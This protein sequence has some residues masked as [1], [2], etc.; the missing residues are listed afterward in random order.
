MQP[1]V[2]IETE[3]RTAETPTLNAIAREA[4]TDNDGS[5]DYAV[6][7]VLARL[8]RNP[9]AYVEAIE[10]ALESGVRNAVERE[11]RATRSKIFYGAP[12][13][14]K[15]NFTSAV[16]MLAETNRQML[17]DFPLA[18]GVRLRDAT[19]DQVLTQAE[20]YRATESDARRKRRWLEAIAG[21]VSDG[22]TVGDAVSEDKARYLLEEEQ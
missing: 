14:S 7:E 3:D 4:L 20:M 13:A 16:Q 11:M 8:N 19:R 17:L 10:E 15:I 18:G 9:R 12:P 1:Q 5:V 2:Q 6:T 22:Q 21:L